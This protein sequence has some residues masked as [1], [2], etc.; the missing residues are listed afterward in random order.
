MVWRTI[1]TGF[2]KNLKFTKSM[3]RSMMFMGVIN[4]RMEKLWY[5]KA[6]M[7]IKVF[8]WMLIQ[9]KLQT[10]VNMKK[11]NWQGSRNC[12][13]CGSPETT[14]HIFFNCILVETI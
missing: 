1:V 9:H 6:P 3:Y 13:L 2:L 12:Y 5:N 8:M 14:D 11:K 7:K 4:K 10:G